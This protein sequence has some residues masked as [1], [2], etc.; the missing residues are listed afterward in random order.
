MAKPILRGIFN[1]GDLLKIT[2]KRKPKLLAAI[3]NHLLLER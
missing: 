1:Q 2:S 3:S